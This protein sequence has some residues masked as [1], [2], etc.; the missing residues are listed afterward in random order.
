MSDL[1]NRLRI[2]LYYRYV[3]SVSRGFDLRS[4]GSKKNWQ[5]QPICVSCDSRTL[6]WCLQHKLQH[7]WLQGENCEKLKPRAEKNYRG[8]FEIKDCDD[9]AI[10]E[11]RW[12]R[13]LGSTWPIWLPSDVLVL[14]IWSYLLYESPVPRGRLVC[15]SPFGP[16]ALILLFLAS[17]GY[18]LSLSSSVFFFF[19]TFLFY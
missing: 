11:F 9:W 15:P 6:G 16:V 17:C 4:T 13:D 12:N 10:F 7:Q 2:G 5:N 3:W 18:S 14:I 1:F 19:P 8:R